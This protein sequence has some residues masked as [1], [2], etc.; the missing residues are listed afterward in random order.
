MAAS[1][2]TE[3]FLCISEQVLNKI[4]EDFGDDDD[5]GSLVTSQSNNVGP[6]AL[7]F[8]PLHASF[9]PVL[10]AGVV[11]VILSIAFLSLFLNSLVLH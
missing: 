11:G 5:S 8:E 2:S 10:Y 9:A 3:D 7:M 4:L 1:F 6:R